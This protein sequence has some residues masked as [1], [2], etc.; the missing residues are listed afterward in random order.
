[1]KNI[2]YKDDPLYNEKLTNSPYYDE[3]EF[4]WETGDYCK[5]CKDCKDR[6]GII[7]TYKGWEEIGMPFSKILACS[8]DD[9]CD[10]EMH[11]YDEGLEGLELVCRNCSSQY[12]RGSW[13]YLMLPLEAIKLDCNTCKSEQWFDKRNNKTNK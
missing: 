2:N 12:T 5:N 13:G 3:T 11:S 9:T 8:K 6:D 4:I 7:K 1:M 10:C